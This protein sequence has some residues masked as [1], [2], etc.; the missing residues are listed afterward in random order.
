MTFSD[1]S[2]VPKVMQ[3]GEHLID[4]KRVGDIFVSF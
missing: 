3:G 4:N 1:P 2:S